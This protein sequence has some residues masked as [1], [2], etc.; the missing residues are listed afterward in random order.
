MMFYAGCLVW[1]W[2][3]LGLGEAR[4]I[5]LQS[6]IPV[7]SHTRACVCAFMYQSGY[8]ARSRRRRRAHHVLHGCNY[9]RAS[10]LAPRVQ[11]RVVVSCYFF[12]RYVW[13]N[14]GKVQAIDCNSKSRSPPRIDF[15][16][17]MHDVRYRC[18]P[19]ALHLRPGGFGLIDQAQGDFISFFI[20]ARPGKQHAFK[21][22][23]YSKV[24][25]RVQSTLANAYSLYGT[26]KTFE[27]HQHQAR[28]KKRWATATCEENADLAG[29]ASGKRG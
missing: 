26:R 29:R 11:M 23:R 1:N 4:Y 2:R 16:R 9:S 22:E 19:L 25:L 15:L 3:R 24:P 13:R 18:C 8:G 6:Y 12:P 27:Y 21:E 14:W 17:A 28:R 7:L 10:K 5:V 20:S